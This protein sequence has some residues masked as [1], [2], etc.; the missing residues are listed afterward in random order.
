[1]FPICFYIPLL[2][3]SEFSEHFLGLYDP[4]SNRIDLDN[5]FVWPGE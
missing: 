1:M 5:E 4:Y 2:L 3:S